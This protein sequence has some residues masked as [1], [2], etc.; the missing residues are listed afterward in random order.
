[1]LV[2]KSVSPANDTVISL[3][4]STDAGRTTLIEEPS[5]V[6]SEEGTVRIEPSAFLNTIE[7]LSLIGSEKLNTNVEAFSLVKPTY[8]GAT[9]SSTFTSLVEAST[10]SPAV[11]FTESVTATLYSP[12]NVVPEIIVNDFLS[13]D[14]LAVKP[15]SAV[16]PTLAT[17]MLVRASEVPITEASSIDLLNVTLIS[18]ALI[19]FY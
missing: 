10:L 12:L 9:L 8:V 18:L 13:S 1:M 17:V 2:A 5:T 3:P 14:N 11:V 6:M 15:A 19:A 16:A 7:P 4:A